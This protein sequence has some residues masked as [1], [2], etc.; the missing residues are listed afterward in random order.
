LLVEPLGR[1]AVELS[2]IRVQNHLL[3]ADLKARPLLGVRYGAD[4][5][6]NLLKGERA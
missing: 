4:K 5:R 1:D 3:T 2:Q 6:L